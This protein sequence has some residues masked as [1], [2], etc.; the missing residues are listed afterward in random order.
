MAKKLKGELFYLSAND[1]K[2][3][4][5][6]YYSNKSWSKNL[7]EARVIRREEIEEFERIA[8]LNE[9]K[10]KIVS[11]TFVELS[12]DGKI[13]KLRDIIRYKGITF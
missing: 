12:D 11:P 8:E 5:V 3:G 7:K 4:E 10:C 9:K 2:T 13:K 1:L 6:V